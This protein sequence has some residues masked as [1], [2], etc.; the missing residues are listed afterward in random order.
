M[1][2]LVVMYANTTPS[3]TGQLEFFNVAAFLPDFEI[4]CYY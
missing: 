4:S 1:M 3:W 2:L